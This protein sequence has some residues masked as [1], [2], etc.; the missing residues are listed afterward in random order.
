V[1]NVGS[2][3]FKL[4]GSAKGAGK[5]SLI[6]T[7]GTNDILTVGHL[8]SN[9]I[10]LSLKDTSGNIVMQTSTPAGGGTSTN[11]FAPAISNGA[12]TVDIAGT[13][14]GIGSGS[15]TTVANNQIAING[16]G[17]IT[18]IGTGASTTV[19][20]NQIAI[21]GTG[22]ITGI[23][24]GAN[25]TV[26][27]SQITISGGQIS[28]IGTGNNSYVVKNLQDASTWMPGAA[29]PW[30]L[31]GNANENSI[32]WGTG[33]KG[34]T[35]PLWKC[36]SSGDGEADGGWNYP[37]SFRVDKN[38]TYRFMLPFRMEV[39]TGTSG[40]VYLGIDGNSVCDLN[41]S[42]K[43]SNPYFHAVGRTAFTINRWYLMVGFIYPAGST[44]ASNTG[45]HIYDMTTGA[46]VSNGVN[47]CWASDVIL[48]GTRA[49]L[50]YA[51][52]AGNI[53]YFAGPVVEL[54]DGSESSINEL[55]QASAIYN[56]SISISSGAIQG[57]GTGNGTTV[58]NSSITVDGS[59]ILQGVGTANTVVANNQIAINGSGQLTGI[60][61]GVNTTVVIRTELILVRDQLLLN[62]ADTDG[63]HQTMF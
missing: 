7:D 18:G 57:I 30:G 46:I 2:T 29:P 39:I 28:G 14:Q 55:L 1:F 10:G 17:Q 36:T 53:Q 32:V 47:Y 23:G 26:A 25:T 50:Y 15:G 31:N 8:D 24:T 58:A 9:N 20:N 34:G 33:P 11:S 41:T 42:T 4:D 51:T 22:Q 52:T 38:K 63:Q 3:K 19:A 43:N 35:I 61:S 49:Y 21:N 37:S 13:I 54:V 45:A 16:S 59:G 5:G 6:V 12:I 40:S 62:L 27:N 44:G 56:Q 60:G 48:S